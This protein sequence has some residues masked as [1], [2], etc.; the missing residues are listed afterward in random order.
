M[1]TPRNLDLEVEGVGPIEVTVADDGTGRPFL[2]LHGGAGAQSVAA[3]ADLL[4]ASR[5]AHVITPTHP[6]FGVTPRPDSLDSIGG[7]ARVYTALLDRLDVQHVTVVG[8]SMGGW[9]AA[10]M[11]LLGSSRIAGVISRAR[12][13][14]C[15]PPPVTCPISRP[16]NS[17]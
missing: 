1:T 11:A 13:S 5:Q 7:L 16:P 3:F 12:H 9:I 17:C 10:E 4:V 2:L 8:N 14:P 6:G 15:S